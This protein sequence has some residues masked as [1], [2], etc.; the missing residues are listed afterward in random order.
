[1]KN[2]EIKLF[3]FQEKGVEYLLANKRCGIFDDAGLGKTLQTIEAVKRGGFKNVLVVVPA[4]LRTQ[5][6]KQFSV[7][8]C[9]I[10]PVVVSYNYIQ[11]EKNAEF[12]RSKVWDCV[13]ADECQALGNWTAKQTRNFALK[14]I[15]KANRVW[16]LSGTP[17]IR[18]AANWHP[19]LSIIEPGK[20]GKFGDF[21]KRFCEEKTVYV[22]TK[23]R[24]QHK[25]KEI[26]SW[27]GFKQPE[28][29]NKAVKAVSIRR[30]AE[31]TEHEFPDKIYDD[32]YVQVD[33]GLLSER[34][35]LK[36]EEIIKCLVHGTPIPDHISRIRRS[37]GIA[38]VYTCVEHVMMLNKR[39]IIFAWHKEVIH[40]LVQALS[41]N[42]LGCSVITGDVKVDERL[43]AV[44]M[45]ES[46]KVDCLVISIAAGGTGLNIPSCKNVLFLE[47]PWS[48]AM[49]EQAED[50]AR[51]VTSTKEHIQ[52]TTIIG[53]GTIDEMVHKILKKKQDG[54]L[55]VMN[56]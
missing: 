53:S 48:A 27:V 30:T 28:V 40:N 20:W 55:A 43:K 24:G 17:A 51:R 47:E 35:A 45:F 50:R 29:L 3:P 15:E 33:S 16:L 31:E 21:C 6:I 36:E 19:I 49:K 8:K 2:E 13:I 56:G 38:K 37:I 14:V 26:K 32:L 54:M 18:S 34:L 4:Y 42:G 10:T 23:Y 11:L 52:I 12:L 22:K 25:V 7:M 39:C 1:M 9:D 44:E 41:E 5:W 46:G